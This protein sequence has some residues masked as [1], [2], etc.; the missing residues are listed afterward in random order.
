MHMCQC[1]SRLGRSDIWVLSRGGFLP[2][3]VRVMGRVRIRD[4]VRI[5]VKS[6]WSVG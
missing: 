4:M 5:G 6:S 1:L 2:V 3:R